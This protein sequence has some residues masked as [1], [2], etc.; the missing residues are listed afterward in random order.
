M[1]STIKIKRKSDAA[2]APGSLAEG[3]LAVNLFSRKLYVGNSSGVTAISG[4]TYSLTSQ[5]A[6]SGAYLKVNGE[7]SG[8]TVL[9]RS[10]SGISVGRDANGSISVAQDGTLQTVAQSKAYLANTNAYIATNAATELSHLA[11]TNAYIATRLASAS[12]TAADV[13]TKIKTVDGASS[14]LDADLLD[15]QQGSYYAVE[16]TEKLR[17][18]NTNAYIATK[19]NSSSYTEADVRSKAALANTNAYI[20]ATAAT[21]LA[22]L[23][24]T[25]A[26]IA[27]KLDSS[28]YTTADVRSK[29]ALANTN[30][31]I[32]NVKT[33]ATNRLG[34]TATVQLTGDVTA[35]PTAFSSN[36]V[37]L[38]TTIAD[39]SIALGTKTT[40][41]YVATITGTANEV[42]VS[43]SGSETASVT[44]GLPDNVTIT[45]N[46]TVSGNTHID[47][48]LIV[49]GATTYL[50]TST[51]YTDDGMMKLN[52]NNAADTIDSGV[53]NLYIESATS[54]Y[55]GYF[56]DATDGVFK[57]YDGLQSEPSTTV[58]T[59]ATGYALAQLDAII[60]GGT[61]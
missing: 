57:F 28:S 19:L 55:A 24:N 21:E 44:I 60:D 56:R 50:S 6:G 26:Y 9:L 15:G 41:N 49:E 31:Y 16:A 40:G 59:G 61:Y 1:A 4:E 11:N 27:T 22:H 39:N 23:A 47:G 7:T 13:L 42:T 36:T 33:I 32:A 3:E 30:A 53:Y 14:G 2:G 58:N 25:N 43:G 37:S 10:G 5:T 12:Y 29:A 34:Q 46:L 52:A 38:S 48:N 8:N 35:G 17:L 20:A 51:V 54:K 18:A 45:N